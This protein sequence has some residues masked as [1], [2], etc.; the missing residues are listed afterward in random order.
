MPLAGLDRCLA[1]NAELQP[2]VTKALE[3]LALSRLCFRVLPPE[4]ADKVRVANLTD[5]RLVLLASTPSIAAKLKMHSA[6]LNN[7][8]SKLGI[9]VSEVQVRVQ[10]MMSHVCDAAPRKDRRLSASALRDLQELHR[11]MSNSPAKQALGLLLEHN[12]PGS[13]A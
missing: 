13:K 2:T 3:I 8:L 6:T 9:Q 5:G 11:R 4:F 10:P 12:S 1:A 7:S